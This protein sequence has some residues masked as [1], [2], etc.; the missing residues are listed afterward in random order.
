MGP[1][2]NASTLTGVALVFGMALLE[3][4]LLA[5]PAFAVGAK[6]QSRDLALLSATGA[7]RTHVRGTVLA[8]GVVLG[9]VGGVVGVLGGIA[10]ALVAQPRVTAQTL[11]YPGPFELRPVELLAIV[12]LGVLTAVLACVMPAR[13][14]SRQNVVAA[15]TGRRGQRTSLRRTPVLG[16]AAAVAGTLVALHGAQQRSIN[17]ILAGSAIA[18]LGLVATTPFLVGVAGRLGRFLPLAPRLAVRDAARNRGRTAPAVSA[19]LAAVAGS[20]AVGTYIASLD[21]YNE[22]NYERTAPLGTTTVLLA[23]E[24]GHRAS[25]IAAMLQQQLPKSSVQVVVRAQRPDGFDVRFV[26][27]KYG[28]C[29]YTSSSPEALR[30]GVKDPLCNGHALRSVVG[31]L[32]VG[33]STTVQV[34][35]GISGPDFGTYL[36]HF[37]EVLAKGGAVVPVG[38][39]DQGRGTATLEVVGPDQRRLAAVTVQAAVLPR[40]AIQ[41]AVLSPAVA[42]RLGAKMV[43]AAVMARGATA[44]S[45]L[46]ED[47]I[48]SRLTGLHADY[49]V[50]VERGYQGGSTTGMLALLIGS[51][52]IVLG[53]SGI[54]TGLAAADGKADL[55]TLA[56]VGASPSA[57]RTLAAFQ[58][59]VTAVLGTLLGIAAGLVPAVG[60]VRAL[61]SAARASSFPRFDPY[62]LVLPWTNI[63]LT[64]LVVPLVAALAAALLT[65]SKLPL[66]R[67]LA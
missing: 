16:V 29:A 56:A 57:R 7:D 64:V 43:P 12:G 61:N 14:A 66:V 54:A 60:M 47:R 6:R 50:S 24:D 58:S 35:T 4:V 30:V 17:T 3:I 9:V 11:T 46:V 45:P 31:G 44:P 8:S 1:A 25:T 37:A 62:P 52:I 55:A 23:E 15:L 13:T 26:P 41:V 10:V 65:P 20:V 48:H 28:V 42:H 36:G 63:L 53:A 18:E 22:Q 59:A 51:A 67:R 40:E 5:G 32:P 38:A 2:L 19:V 39:F 49:G 34:L 27:S 33:D 21:R